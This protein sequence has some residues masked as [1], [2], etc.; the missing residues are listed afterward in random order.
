LTLGTYAQRFVFLAVSFGQF[1]FLAK[2]HI[3]ISGEVAVLERVLL[4]C[5]AKM[6]EMKKGDEIL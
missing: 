3:E 4:T 6:S 2:T 1:A 5:E